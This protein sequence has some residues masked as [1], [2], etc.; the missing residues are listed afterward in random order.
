[1]LIT[2]APN[3]GEVPDKVSADASY[4]R[5]TNLSLLDKLG[6][7]AYIA[8]DKDQRTAKKPR[9]EVGFRVGGT[10]RAVAP[11][12]PDEERT[13]RLQ[14]PQARGRARALNLT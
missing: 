5:E 8:V 3:A 14:A 4:S 1:M 11:E 10:P 9:R 6:I 2:I 7:G 13:R 12:D